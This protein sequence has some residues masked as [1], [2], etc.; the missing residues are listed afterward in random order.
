MRAREMQFMNSFDPYKAWLGI[1][2]QER[3]LTHE[4]LL[5]LSPQETDPAV[6]HAAA[7]TLIRRVRGFIASVHAEEALALVGELAS[8]RD[9]LLDPTAKA[10]DEARVVTPPEAQSATPSEVQSI[11]PPE[12]Q[13]TPESPPAK[14]TP[15]S[16]LNL[17]YVSATLADKLRP[18]A[19]RHS[20]RR[21]TA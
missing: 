17:R 12:A 16:R 19:S 2:M 1:P 6:I 13:P 21:H 4:R 15:T 5:G 8:A 11:T 9:R 20:H 18:R 10:N 14:I 7:E 3:P